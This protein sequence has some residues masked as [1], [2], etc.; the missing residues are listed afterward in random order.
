MD[1]PLLLILRLEGPFQSWGERARWD[2]RD[3]A[4]MPTKSGIIGLLACAIGIPRNSNRLRE[5]D[6]LIKIGVRGDRPG[7]LLQDY[8]TITGEIST[9]EGKSRGTKNSQSTLQSWRHY[10]TDA[11]FLVVLSGDEVLLEECAEAL[12][13]PVWPVY[14]GRKCCVP[15]RPVLETKTKEF[16]SLEDA[17]QR[18]SFEWRTK[19]AVPPGVTGEIEDE[20]GDIVRRDR[21]LGI[22]AR[23]YGYRRTR[24]FW[25]P[26][27]KQA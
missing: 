24:S 3:T 20:R 8:Q 1:K 2:I 22:P 19:E 5:M 21:I 4:L 11:S 14:L 12:K 23:V 26:C 25:V 18:Y 16:S 13:H 15:T 6:V 17:L 10:L 27:D 7:L 9:A